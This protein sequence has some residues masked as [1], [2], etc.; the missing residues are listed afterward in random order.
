[1]TLL[2][3]V[4]LSVAAL[5]YAR[6][7]VSVLPL[8]TTR[9]D[10]GCGCD[11]GR[12][13]CDSPGKHPH[14]HRI[15][16][17]HGLR[18][19]TTRPDLIMQWWARW[20]GANIGL[21]T[22][23][24]FDVCDIDSR[25][26]LAAM[27]ELFGGRPVGGP[28]V[29][30]GSGG[31]HL[32]LRPTGA[33]NRAALLPGVDWRGAG[34]YVVAPPSRH[35]SGNHYR[36]IRPP[37]TPLA[38][39]PPPLVAL[40]RPPSD[41]SPTSD[42]AAEAPAG[43]PADARPTGIPAAVAPGSRHPDRYASAL[44]AEIRHPDRYAAAALTAEATATAAA[45]PGHR[46]TTLYLAAHHL[47]QLAAVGLLDDRDIVTTL[48]DAARR[49]GLGHREIARTIRSGLRAGRRWP[50]RRAIPGGRPG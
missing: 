10:G 17:P 16:L 12:S 35:V 30:T 1:M 42:L 24:R 45:T 19:A 46:N 22:G 27:R 49:A 38:D 11:C 40:L 6:V 34:G 20:P 13:D 41:A 5:R 36:W 25:D 28:L 37:G 23:E 21:R 50:R 4:P 47:G 29:R 31:W 43:T 7:G 9:G 39:P 32:Y 14:W 48:A 3:T 26:G 2:T 44:T 18:D 33:G 8:H 15:L